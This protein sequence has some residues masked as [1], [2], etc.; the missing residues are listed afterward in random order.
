[1]AL[2]WRGRAVRPRGAARA[3]TA[4]RRVVD[5]A[6]SSRP[7][8]FDDRSRAFCDQ[9]D[10]DHSIVG[11]EERPS[12][13]CGGAAEMTTSRYGVVMHPSLRPPYRLRLIGPRRTGCGPLLLKGLRC[14]VSLRCSAEATLQ[15]RALDQHAG[16]DV[17]RQGDEKLARQCDDGA[18]APVLRS[19]VPAV[20]RARQRRLRLRRIHSQASWTS[21]SA[22]ADAGLGYAL[23]MRDG[24]LC[25]GVAARPA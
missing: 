10:A 13:C 19:R 22:P 25:Q 1:M 9:F 7:G 8:S 21:W 5:D 4:L 12:D 17:L 20:E 23:L 14:R 18:L 3:A 24:P 16:A 15:R 6:V 11:A 2:G